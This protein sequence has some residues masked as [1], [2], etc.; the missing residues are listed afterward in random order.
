MDQ[1]RNAMFFQYSQRL[2]RLFRVIILR[3][4][5]TALP[6]EQYLPKPPSSL[7]SVFRI[8]TMGIEDVHILPIPSVSDFGQDLPSD[9]YGFPSFRTYARPHIITGLCRNKK[10][11]TVSSQA[12]FSE[13]GRNSLLPNHRPSRNYFARSK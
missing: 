4:L 2:L 9:T 12:F 8:R 3:Y 13:S 5:H 6:G 1:A 7:L 10:F 11:V